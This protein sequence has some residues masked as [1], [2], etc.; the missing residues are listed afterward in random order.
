MANVTVRELRN[1]SD[2]VIDRVL[3]GERVI[4]TRGG[5]AVAE[6]RPVAPEALS[7]AALL[8][9]WR[10]VPVAD[11]RRL[12]ADLDAQIDPKLGACAGPTWETG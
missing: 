4:V 11:L 6:L 12:R 5:R 1:Q 2:E 7:A 10:S 9:R 8:E 3:S